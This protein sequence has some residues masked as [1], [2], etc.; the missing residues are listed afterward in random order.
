MISSLAGV[1][2]S[3]QAPPSASFPS[4]PRLIGPSGSLLRCW[5]DE[6]QQLRFGGRSFSWTFLRAE[7]AF[8]IIGVDFLRHHRLLLDAAAD[9][10]MIGSSG[11]FIS[12]SRQPSGPTA[13][14]CV[15]YFTSTASPIRPSKRISPP[16][17]LLSRYL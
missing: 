7:V 6:K 5:G 1:F 14:A 16:M 10:L 12:L 8:P 15:I 13:Y 2:L 3:I 4:G 9:R 11:R 17:C